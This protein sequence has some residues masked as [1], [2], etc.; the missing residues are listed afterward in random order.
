[1]TGEDGEMCMPHRIYDR[2]QLD[3]LYPS[4]EVPRAID[5]DDPFDRIADP[6]LEHGNREAERI[7]QSAV[8]KG[9]RRW[10]DS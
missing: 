5:E 2:T 1:M 6:I 10:A 9:R 8:V 7:V 3:E 4:F